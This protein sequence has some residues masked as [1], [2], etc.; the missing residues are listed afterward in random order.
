MSDMP[1]EEF[2]QRL[3]EAVDAHDR[4]ALEARYQSMTPLER[5]RRLEEE[6]P[7]LKEQCLL[8]RGLWE[9]ETIESG[10]RAEGNASAAMCVRWAIEAKQDS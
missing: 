5:F 7:L 9:L 4:A 10:Y 8:D 6:M 3:Q 1:P 2:A